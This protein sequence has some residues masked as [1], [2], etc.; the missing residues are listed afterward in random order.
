MSPEEYLNS[1]ADPEWDGLRERGWL[2]SNSSSTEPIS[3]LNFLDNIGFNTSKDTDGDGIPDI[4]DPKTFDA[5]NL[6]TEQIKEIYGNDLAWTD[7]LRMWIGMS[8]RDF[9]GDGVPDSVESSKNMDP[10]NPDTD[11]D[12]ILDGDE[13]FRGTD[14]LNR[15]TDGDGTL[16]GRDAYPL[17]PY[18]T[19]S[20]DDV[21]TDGDGVGDHYEK[22]IGTDPNNRDTDGDGMYDNIDPYPTDSHNSANVNDVLHSVAGSGDGGL[23]LSIQ[24]HFLSFLSD[25]L[26]LL[27]LFMLPITIFIFYLWFMR[28]RHAVEH[29]EHLFHDAIGYKGIF[30]KGHNHD[31]HKADHEDHSSEVVHAHNPHVVAHEVQP[32]KEVEYVKHPRWAMIEDYMAADHE[33][34]WRIG[35]LEAD[36][37]LHDTLRVAGYPGEDLGEMLKEANFRSID[38][39]WDAHKL[40]NRIAHEGM[41]FTLTQRDARRAFAEYEAVFKELKII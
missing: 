15:D 38:L 37:L 16:D 5:H 1:V 3:N 28:M 36:N 22:L 2:N 6:T 41:K 27:S 18:R 11:H 8:P 4:R 20:Y 17:D 29:Y 35:I 12:G 13:L 7:H 26:T 19:Y 34:L 30:D 39:A 9:D 32:P 33:T 31:E 23:T 25:I 21:D 10:N 40:R 14:P 24:N